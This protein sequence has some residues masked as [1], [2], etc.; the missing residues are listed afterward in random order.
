[1]GVEVGLPELVLPDNPTWGQKPVPQFGTCLAGAVSHKL[2][3]LDTGTLPA[4]AAMRVLVVK[5]DVR[6]AS[7]FFGLATNENEIDEEV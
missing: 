3:V 5:N 2:R 6:L 4:G 1:M 7:G